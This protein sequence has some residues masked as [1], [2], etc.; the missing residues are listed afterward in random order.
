MEIAMI[1]AE[2]GHLVVSTLHTIN[3]GQ[4]IS[5]ILGFFTRDEEVQ[6]RHRLAE[7][8]RYIVSQRLVHSTTEARLL[9]TEVMGSSLRTRE[10]VRYGESE[11]KTFQEIIEAA[12]TLGWHTFDQSLLKACEADLVTDET[13]MLYCTN[14][15]SMHRELDLLAKRQG[16]HRRE[17]GSGLKLDRPGPPIPKRVITPSANPA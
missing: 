17:P 15:S 14:K 12:T 3:A 16:E 10:T 1:A 13:A 2:T 5:R 11:S 4:S 8:L 7:T 9:I 6:T